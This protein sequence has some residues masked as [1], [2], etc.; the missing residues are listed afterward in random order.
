VG[1]CCWTN[2]LPVY[3]ATSKF[4]TASKAGG[5][6]VDGGPA[7]GAAEES[8]DR[9]VEV[10]ARMAKMFIFFFCRKMYNLL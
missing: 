6:Q 2:H 7:N 5:G 3:A 8:N 9:Q 10:A 1:A 4:L